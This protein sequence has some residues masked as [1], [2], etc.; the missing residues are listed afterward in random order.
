MYEKQIERHQRK[1]YK[2]AAKLRKGASNMTSISSS[3]APKTGSPVGQL[4][5]ADYSFIKGVLFHVAVGA[6][7]SILSAVYLH[8][9]FGQYQP[10]ATLVY[11][12]LSALLT[13]LLNGK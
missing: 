13:Q 2:R 11:S 12:G 10:V 4:N 7:I 8:F 9:S 1:L 3:F 5:T 6:V